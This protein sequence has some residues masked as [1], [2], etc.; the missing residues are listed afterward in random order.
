MTRNLEALKKAY[1]TTGELKAVS[2]LIEVRNEEEKRER[3][4]H[5]DAEKQ[6]VLSAAL[7]VLSK[8]DYKEFEKFALEQEEL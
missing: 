5:Y 7:W 4:I 3:R 8:K 2:Q 1:R 6:G